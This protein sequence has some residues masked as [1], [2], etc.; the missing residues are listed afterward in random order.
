MKK[1]LRWEWGGLAESSHSIII[2][3]ILA[4]FFPSPA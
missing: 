4:R 2:V 1:A 3:G